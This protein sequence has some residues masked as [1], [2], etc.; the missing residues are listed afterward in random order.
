[1]K[2]INKVLKY[3]T[4]TNRYAPVNYD[5]TVQNFKELGFPSVDKEH[6]LLFEKDSDKQPRF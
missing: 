3:F 5:A 1:M 2:Y 4:F 6:V